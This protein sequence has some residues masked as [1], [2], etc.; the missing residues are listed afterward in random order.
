M[1]VIGNHSDSPFLCGGGEGS[2]RRGEESTFEGVTL[3]LCSKGREELYGNHGECDS[4]NT[5]QFWC[6]GG[7]QGEGQKERGSLLNVGWD[8]EE[9]WGGEGWSGE[10]GR[11]EAWLKE[12]YLV[13]EPFVCNGC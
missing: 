8:V 10:E 6:V 13:A 3:V 1:V 12:G 5:P 11:R 2:W 7:G 4:P 9:R